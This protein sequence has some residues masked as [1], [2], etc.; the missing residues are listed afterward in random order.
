MLF[1][2]RG[3]CEATRELIRDIERQKSAGEPMKNTSMPPANDRPYLAVREGLRSDL[4]RAAG[5]KE[6]ACSAKA[7]RCFCQRRMPT[8]KTT[9]TEL[10]GVVAR[11]GEADNVLY[12]RAPAAD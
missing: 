4:C 2:S 6:V 8:L 5:S 3:L 1:L 10:Q 9:S 11:P 12:S 7:Q